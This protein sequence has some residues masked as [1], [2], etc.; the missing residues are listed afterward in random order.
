MM[1]LRE[2][3]GGLL[4]GKNKWYLSPGLVS[5]IIEGDAS[6]SQVGGGTAIEKCMD[7]DVKSAFNRLLLHLG[8]TAGSKKRVGIN[9]LFSSGCQTTVSMP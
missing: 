2:R 8:I 4:G 1:A 7:I 6:R 5:P 3:M 9:P